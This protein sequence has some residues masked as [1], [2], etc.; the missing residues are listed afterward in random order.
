MGGPHVSEG[1]D[2]NVANLLDVVGYNYAPYAGDYDA[3]HAAHPTWKIFGS[4]TTAAVRSRSVYHTP[5][6]TITKSN[7]G[8]NP[9]RQCSSYDNETARFGSTRSAG[10][11]SGSATVAAQ[12]R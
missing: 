10:L 8:T 5:A 11:T 9:D 12:S 7:D 1:D 3:D 6:S 2:R 4:E